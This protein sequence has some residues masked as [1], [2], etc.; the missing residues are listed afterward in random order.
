MNEVRKYSIQHPN[1]RE[2][3][4]GPYVTE[5]AT[6]PKKISETEAKQLLEELKLPL[7][8]EEKKIIAY[9]EHSIAFR[10]LG[11]GNKIYIGV[12]RYPGKETNLDHELR[13]IKISDEMVA[14][15]EGHANNSWHVIAQDKDS[16]PILL[17]ISPEIQGSTLESIG[18]LHLLGNPEALKNYVKL[19]KKLMQLITKEKSF[20]ITGFEGFRKF[21]PFVSR[22]I[23]LNLGSSEV[24]AIDVEVLEE[25]EKNKFS[26][27]KGATKL[28]LYFSN[29]SFSALVATGVN[30]ILDSTHY[31]SDE[32]KFDNSKETID[33]TESLKKIISLMNESG[34][35]YRIVGGFAYA[36]YLQQ[37][38]VEYELSANRFDGTKRDVDIFI[39]SEKDDAYEA[40]K[41]KIAL[42]GVNLNLEVSIQRLDSHEPH[43]IRTGTHIR[44][45]GSIFLQFDTLTQNLPSSAFEN[46]TV[47]YNGV[48]FPTLPLA[49]L[50]GQTISRQGSIPLQDL[51]KIGLCYEAYP[52][53]QVPSEYLDMA[54]RVREEKPNEYR[55]WM[56]KQW[57]ELLT[58]NRTN[59]VVKP[60]KSLMK[61]LR[62]KNPV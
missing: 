25:H 9:G 47:T 52:K 32:K 26:N 14:S 12:A 2:T 17:K 23:V 42:E 38:G 10:F 15:L 34:L 58:G 27:I 60:I 16:R 5:D 13:T 48:S 22:N 37:A 39:L 28:L 56:I 43:H 36:A 33:T 59:K 24:T 18:V 53:L 51:A 1:S 45:D 8:N 4:F 29:I 7:A 31:R 11:P 46:T 62:R 57:I 35:E 20:D 44:E 61:I 3:F 55:H 54:K 40:L 41:E 19:C 50:V 30:S 21:L 6:L 49:S